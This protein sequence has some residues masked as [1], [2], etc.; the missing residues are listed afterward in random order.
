MTHNNPVLE[1]FLVRSILQP[2]AAGQQNLPRRQA[3][4]LVLI[5]AH[6]SPTLLLT[7]RDATLRKHA[8]QVAFPSRMIDASLV[9]TALR[10]AA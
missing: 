1:R 9:A 5:V 7:R 4:I 8:G 10:E 3:A 2:P 6:A